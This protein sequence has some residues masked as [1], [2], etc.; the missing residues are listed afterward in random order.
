MLDSQVVSYKATMQCLMYKGVK[1]AK[2]SDFFK[3]YPTHILNKN[4]SRT[5][6]GQ[7]DKSL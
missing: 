4:A 2:A 5:S 7:S 1:T 6:S 3:I